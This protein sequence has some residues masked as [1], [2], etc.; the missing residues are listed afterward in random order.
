MRKSNLQIVVEGLLES[1]KLSYS[2]YD[3]HTWQAR[4]RIIRDTILSL[5]LLIAV[6]T[7]KH[8]ELI[9]ILDH[10]KS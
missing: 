1:Q 5:A 7:L 2:Y 6:I 8:Q 9:L 10:L 4:V 3:K